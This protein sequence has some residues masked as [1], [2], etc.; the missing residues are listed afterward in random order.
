MVMKEGN[1]RNFEK[2][3]NRFLQAIV[4]IRFIA[5]KMNIKIR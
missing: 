5:E 4:D 1:L 3:I 2:L